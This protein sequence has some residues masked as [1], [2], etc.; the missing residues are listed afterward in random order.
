MPLAIPDVMDS[1]TFDEQAIR[2]FRVS[3]KAETIMRTATLVLFTSIWL[4][5]G[6]QSAQVNTPPPK[7]GGFRL[8]LKAGSVRHAA[9][10]GHL[11]IIIRLRWRLVFDVSIQTS[12]VTLPLLAT[13]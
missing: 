13:Q 11:E 7:G 4:T 1:H 9:D 12:S 8:R 5:V 3:R 2:H 10:S 6:A